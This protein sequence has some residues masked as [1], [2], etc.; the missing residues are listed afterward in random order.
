MCMGENGTF[1]LGGVPQAKVVYV[2][3]H[4]Q[5]FVEVIFISIQGMMTEPMPEVDVCVCVC[6]LVSIL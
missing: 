1:L 4:L 2:C 3:S 6:Q 5:L